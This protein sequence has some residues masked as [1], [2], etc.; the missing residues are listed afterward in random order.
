MP[1]T[2]CLTELPCPLERPWSRVQV[3]A[4]RGDEEFVAIPPLSEALE[5]AHR[6]RDELAE[7]D[8]DVQGRTFL[9]LREWT[10][11]EVH[12]AAVNYTN[13][14]LLAGR[15]DRREKRSDSQSGPDR[16]H[17]THDRLC[18]ED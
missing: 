18:P 11:R 3:R 12:H 8:V 5:L 13:R 7:A 15:T 14:L 17:L 16:L 10:R 6:N 9:A 1:E 4:P 2:D